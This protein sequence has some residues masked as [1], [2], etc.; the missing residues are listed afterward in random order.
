MSV[1]LLF[2]DRGALGAASLPV[3]RIVH[4]VYGSR[5]V[6]VEAGVGR[7]SMCGG[8]FVYCV[9]YMIAV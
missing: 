9:T 2:L 4:L 8:V 7:H 3:G 5:M 6:V 1:K